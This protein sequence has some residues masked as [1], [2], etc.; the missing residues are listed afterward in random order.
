MAAHTGAQI[1]PNPHTQDR[2]EVPAHYS[3]QETEE[4]IGKPCY[5]RFVKNTSQDGRKERNAA[6]SAMP[7]HTGAQI[8]PAHTALNMRPGKEGQRKHNQRP[9]GHTFAPYGAVL[10]L[11][12]RTG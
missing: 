9:A 5:L 10:R 7:A 11:L 4:R 3:N 2:A 8:A 6:G 12:L 1:A